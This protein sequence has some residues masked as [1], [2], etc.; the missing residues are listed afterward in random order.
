M[1]YLFTSATVKSLVKLETLI[2]KSCESMKEIIKH[3]NEDGCAEMVFERLKSIKLKSL[4][5]L[6]SFY[7]GNATLQCPCL[8][9]VK[10][11]K[12]P[13]MKTFSEGVMKVPKFSIK[14]SKDSDNSIAILLY[15]TN[16]SGV[17]CG[18]QNLS[19]FVAL[20][21]QFT[22]FSITIIRYLSKKIL[23]IMLPIL[24]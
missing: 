23:L 15:L 16:F 8:K 4:P 21:G 5:R 17:A 3:E 7:S 24:H 6:V 9:M 1:E 19:Y 14:T 2:I 10:V 11:V 13:N 20:T 22:K 12:C 18:Y